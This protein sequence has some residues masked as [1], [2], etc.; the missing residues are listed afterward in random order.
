MTDFRYAV[1]AWIWQG[2][3]A[4]NNYGFIEK[5]SELG[6]DGVEIPTFDGNIDPAV[7]KEKLSALDKNLEVIIV[8]GGSSDM[9]I[10]SGDEKA[11]E[12]GLEYIT[13]L[14]D[15]ASTSGSSLVCGPLYSAVGKALFLKQD[16]KERVLKRTAQ[17][18]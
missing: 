2:D 18:S 13:K 17:C 14:V 8:G 5:A 12:R 6:Y 9:D 16:E 7:I 11:R 1:S 10:S 4:L 15:R 3:P